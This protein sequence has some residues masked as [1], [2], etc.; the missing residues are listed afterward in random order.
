ME[1]NSVDPGGRLARH[2]RQRIKPPSTCRRRAL[3]ERSVIVRLLEARQEIKQD[4]ADG[5]QL[6]PAERV[7]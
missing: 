6:P 3:P 2:R 1:D 4:K 5:N 7:V